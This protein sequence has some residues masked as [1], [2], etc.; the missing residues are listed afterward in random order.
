MDGLGP[1]LLGPG[2]GLPQALLLQDLLLLPAQVLLLDELTPRLLLLLAD[3]VLL[4]F[5]PGGRS[6]RQAVSPGHPRAA[7]ASG[8][9]ACRDHLPGLVSLE[10]DLRLQLLPPHAG[11]LR[12][13][14]LLQEEGRPLLGQLVVR[15]LLVLQG[16][17][18]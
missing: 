14:L 9:R 16:R 7:R 8:A 10:L 6:G 17:A 4:R 13:A 18:T 2:L 11:L 1:W 3:P 15:F 12:L 5:A